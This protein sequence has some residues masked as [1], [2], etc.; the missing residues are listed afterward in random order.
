MSD[1]NMCGLCS[2]LVYIK[3]S[4][5]QNIDFTAYIRIRVPTPPQANRI[6]RA[7]DEKSVAGSFGFMGIGVSN[8]SSL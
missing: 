3:Y 6:R 2:Y 4:H 7:S 1:L 8:Q 5:F